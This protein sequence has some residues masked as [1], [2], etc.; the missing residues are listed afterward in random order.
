MGT[1]SIV[2]MRAIIITGKRTATENRTIRISVMRG[3]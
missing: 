1:H 3:E 2:T